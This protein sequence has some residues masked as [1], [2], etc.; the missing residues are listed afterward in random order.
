MFTS[1]LFL[2]LSISILNFSF[3]EFDAILPTNN[4][5]ISFDFLVNIQQNPKSQTFLFCHQGN[6]NV[7]MF[8][9]LNYNNCKY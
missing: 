1:E 7:K 9:D 5:V 8:C 6:Q 3:S 4:K 2:T